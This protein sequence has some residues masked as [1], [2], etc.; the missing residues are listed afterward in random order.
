MSKI[1]WKDKYNV[2]NETIDSQHQYLVSLINRIDDKKDTG[3][4]NVLK[5]FKDMS[6]YAEKHFSDEELIMKDV[7]YTN[8]LEH[9][10]EH[11]NFIKKLNELY[12]KIESDE[13]IIEEILFFLSDWLVNHILIRD[14]DLATFFDLE[15]EVEEIDL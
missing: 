15:E 5:L 14:K 4:L 12:K 2:G 1:V 13:E 10:K 9:Q 3:K 6:V 7:S 8:Y 11:Y